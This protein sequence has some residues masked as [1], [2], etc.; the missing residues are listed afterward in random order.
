MYMYVYVDIYSNFHHI[1]SVC[2]LCENWSAFEVR[3]YVRGRAHKALMH[4]DA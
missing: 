3:G 2:H 4:T 1:V